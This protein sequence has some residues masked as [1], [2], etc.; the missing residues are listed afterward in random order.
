MRRFIPFLIF[1]IISQSFGTTYTT[2]QIDGTIGNDWETDEYIET[3]IMAG[4]FYRLWIT[5][6]SEYLYVGVDRAE[7]TPKTLFLGDAPEDISLFIA[8]DADPGV[9]NSGGKSDPSG[10]AV[11]YSDYYLPDYIYAFDGENTYSKYEWLGEGWSA[12]VVDSE[13]VVY[14]S[15]AGPL[16]DELSMPW[17]FFGYPDSFVLFIWIT[18]DYPDTILG[19]FP[20]GNPRHGYGTEFP[21]FY[22]YSSRGEG[23]SPYR[24]VY[25]V[26]NE[27]YYDSPGTDAGCFTELKGMTG[28]KLIGY[29]LVGIN[30]AN[31]LPYDT[32][33]IPDA[34]MS[35]DGY[36]VIAQDATVPNYDYIDAAVNW[37]NGPDNVVLLNAMGFV[38]DAVGYGPTDTTTWSFYGEGLPAP[39]VSSGNSL[40]RIPDGVDTDNNQE[41]FSETSILTP[42]IPNGPFYIRGDANVDGNVNVSDAVFMLDNLFPLPS[43]PCRRAVDTN[44]DSTLNTADVIYFLDNL[45]PFPSLPPPDSCGINP[46]DILPCD[47]FPPCGWYG[48]QVIFKI[49]KFDGRRRRGKNGE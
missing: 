26:I 34:T 23:V 18:P 40:S 37:Q 16:D 10:I 42:G 43:F 4:E 5:W 1:L 46:A 35:Q 25:F 28:M 11:F 2:P 20:T 39:D 38:L 8:L 48:N 13:G 17:S 30:G 9:Y 49:L 33:T 45:F 27:V 41:D 44:L 24:S 31:G 29:S 15:C 12:P 22:F 19:T 14:G 36:L 3:E 21:Y 47:S 32:V 6:D 7:C